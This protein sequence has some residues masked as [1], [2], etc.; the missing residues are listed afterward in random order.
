MSPA[1]VPTTARGAALK[2]MLVGFIIPLFGRNSP[3]IRYRSDILIGPCFAGMNA[4][5]LRVNSAP[6]AQLVAVDAGL[7]LGLRQRVELAVEPAA[8]RQI[9]VVGGVT[10]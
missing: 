9:E 1:A 10:D 2:S 5:S 4:V 6:T 7:A 3:R 8:E